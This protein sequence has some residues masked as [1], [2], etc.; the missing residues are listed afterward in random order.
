ME[1]LRLRQRLLLLMLFCWRNEYLPFEQAEKHKIITTQTIVFYR[2][3][4]CA[5]IHLQ[6]P[7]KYRSSGHIFCMR[8]GTAA[9]VCQTLWLCVFILVVA[10]LMRCA[11]ANTVDLE[12]NS[13][14]D[15]I[16]NNE[17]NEHTQNTRK[18]VEWHLSTPQNSIYLKTKSYVR[19]LFTLK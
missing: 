18:K 13:D 1:F 12:M 17:T 2:L 8:R 5:S 9:D 4:L 6:K 3:L 16:G 7:P 19:R 15:F 11:R 10:H 14:S